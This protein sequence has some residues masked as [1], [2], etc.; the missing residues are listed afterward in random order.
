[1]GGSPQRSITSKFVVGGFEAARNEGD[2]VL[3]TIIVSPDVE[4]ARRLETALEPLDGQLAICKTLERYP[5][6]TDLIRTLRAHAPE[7]VFLSFQDVSRAADIVKFLEN[8]AHG[9]QIVAI[10]HVCD[11]PLL[12]ETMRAG[13]RE[14]LADPFD[15]PSIIEAL[16]SVQAQLERKPLSYEASD[17]I[18]AFLP[19]KA[20]VGATTLAL[21]ISAAMAR[22]KGTR[23]MLSDLDL[24]SGM[25]RFLLK[26]RNEHSIVDAVEHAAEIDENLWPQ[27][28]TSI[29]SM[30]VLHAGRVNPNLR[31]EPAQIRHMIQFIRR[32][33][34]AVCFDLSGNL[35]RYS[36]EV[37]QE[38]KRILLV[39]TPEI[40]SLHLARE[41][42]G[43]LKSL[44]LES[45]IN[46]V[47]NRVSK[48]PLFTKEQVEELVGLP[49]VRTFSN[50]YFAVSRATTNGQCLEADSLIG[51]Q[52]DDFGNLLLERRPLAVSTERRKKFLEYFAVPNGGPMA[53]TGTED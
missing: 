23:V 44:G 18:F 36:L 51:K 9:I 42:L 24:N 15:L 4:L 31:V 52:C 28:V 26:L 10:H 45:R 35:E 38:A 30:D 14:F 22:R 39:C 11:A 37:M 8:E 49:V 7:V 32:N 2:N 41:K 5:P 29:G 47:L 46:V 20:G 33:Y 1:M 19:S 53:S 43:F 3:R 27:L 40:P 17:Q 6:A 13:V 48:K 16:H 34:Q 21:N 25:L 50:D 12:R